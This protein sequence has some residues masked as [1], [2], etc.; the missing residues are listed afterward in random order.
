[1]R[2]F[3][4]CLLFLLPLF[5]GN[6]ALGEDAF[7]IKKYVEEHYRGRYARYCNNY[8]HLCSYVAD[9]GCIYIKKSD[10]SRYTPCRAGFHKMSTRQLEAYRAVCPPPDLDCSDTCQDLRCAVLEIDM[11]AA[12]RLIKDG[13]EQAKL[14]KALLLA[15]EQGRAEFVKI[16]LKAG[17][18][19][20]TKGRF[21]Y[22]VLFK[23]IDHEPSV[24]IVKM[25]VAA[26][27]ELTIKGI[28]KEIC[29]PLKGICTEGAI[30]M[31]DYAKLRTLLVYP[32]TV[33]ALKEIISFL[34][35][36]EKNK[37]P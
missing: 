15:A 13:Q 22:S 4:V 14:D 29:S 27:A 2:R 18:N 26:G 9:A 17:A 3:L 10:G 1:M 23:S 7:D 33:P 12:Q 19:A 16:L 25:L 5:F 24:D 34:E 36:A 37:K 8:V 30:R 28:D 20:N 6:V 11:I 35:E 32:K 21:G 31:I